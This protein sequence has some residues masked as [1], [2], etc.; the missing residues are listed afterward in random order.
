MLNMCQHVL[1]EW[2]A[3]ETNP[4]RNLV[5]FICAHACILTG[6]ILLVHCVEILK[7]WSVAVLCDGSNVRKRAE[8]WA[9]V[10]LSLY[11]T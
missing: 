4:H 3:Q 5:S 7:V 10:S 1:S 2:R 9:S 6:A 11:D 8:N